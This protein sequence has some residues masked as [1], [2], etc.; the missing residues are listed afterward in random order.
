MSAPILIAVDGGGTGSRYA[1]RRGAD[2]VQVAGGPANVTSDFDGAI[3]NLLAG[4][5]KLGLS[6]AELAQ[7]RICMG[8]AGVLDDRDAARV[9]QAIAL[10]RLRVV[11]DR[12]IA[13][14]GAFLTT[15]HGA[16]AGIGTGSYVGVLAGGQ[17]RFAGGWGLALGDEAS[18][19]WLGREALKAALAATEGGLRSGLTETLLADGPAAIMRMAAGASANAFGQLAPDVVIAAQAGDFVAINLLRAGAAYLEASLRRLG[20]NKATPLVLTGGLGPVY[21]DY[22][23]AEMQ[24]VL[25]EPEGSALDGA[26]L[27]AAEIT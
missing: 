11:D 15:G 10:P 2:V 18:G 9:A 4:L 25:Q 8:L 17:A 27:Y 24:A 20:W 22:L 7:A 21:L 16:V 1:M 19:A 14:R 23:P 12:A 5:G 26:F 3:T 13:L 6:D